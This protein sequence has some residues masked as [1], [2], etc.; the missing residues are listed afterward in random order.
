MTDEIEDTEEDRPAN[1]KGELPTLDAEAEDFIEEANEDKMVVANA[2]ITAISDTHELG[3]TLDLDTEEEDTEELDDDEPPVK[4]VKPKRLTKKQ[5]MKEIAIRLLAYR[6]RMRGA[7]EWQS[8]KTHVTGNA[9]KTARKIA[10][11]RAR[12]K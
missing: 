9:K 12:K 10:K 5:K 6:E 2:G 3:P 7:K 1:A 8:P 4:P 11:K